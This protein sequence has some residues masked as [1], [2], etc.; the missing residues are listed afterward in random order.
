MMTDPT[1]DLSPLS[2][3][4]LDRLA[5]L[6]QAHGPNAM[7]L[8]EVDGLLV[9]L[10]CSP[11]LLLPSEYMPLILGDDGAFDDIEQAQEFYGLILRHWN[12]IN[13]TLTATEGKDFKKLTADDLYWPV[14]DR[15]E[16]DEVLG[17]EWADGFVAGMRTQWDNWMP[18]LDDE[19]QGGWLVCILAL[20]HE[21]DENPDTK[22]APQTPEQ[23]EYLVTRM[24][25]GIVPIYRYMAPYR[26]L[27]MTMD[28]EEYAPL[29]YAP[30][31]PEPRQVGP[32]IG[33]ND[34][35]PCGS[36]KKYK[37]CCGAN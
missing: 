22:L 9:A 18:M 2:D 23:R 5:E 24:I 37:R 11:R 20:H 28:I 29:R 31:R 21:H 1:A 26:R 6:L 8:P 27:A 33:R 7:S 17:N 3:Q 25:G 15:D 14:V 35:C 13:T 4:E 30:Q 34:P 19:E 32:K 10:I 12:T 16:N 36:G